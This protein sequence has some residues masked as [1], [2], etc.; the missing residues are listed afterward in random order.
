[1]RKLSRSSAL[2]S[3]RVIAGV[4]LLA[5]SSFCGGIG[6]GAMG[7][8]YS[9]TGV[10]IQPE[11]NL[12]CVSPGAQAQ[13][14]AYGSYTEGGHPSKIEDISNQV[15]WSASLPELA[16][17]DSTGLATAANN[18]VGLTSII[19]TTKGEFGD[20]TANS[21]LQVSATC[22]S[23]GTAVVPSKL[24]IVPG[25]QDLR[26][27][28]SL[29]P[30]AVSTATGVPTTVLSRSVSWTSSDDGVAGVDANGVIQAIGPGE[31]TI[32]AMTRLGG[33][34]AVF[35]TE[36]VHVGPGAQQQ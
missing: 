13:F 31:A 22:V 8:T 15:S 11:V 20:L 28:E 36:T 35:A 24:H 23:T 21:S 27:G 34:E 14:K 12:T 25:N 16:S 17:I 9:L 10:Y 29:E 6:C 3:R 30:L 2:F 5:V 4:G 33:H 7:L 1:M 19:A 18:F 26:V 32:T